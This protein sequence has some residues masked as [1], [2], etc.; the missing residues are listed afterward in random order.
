MNTSNIQ[1]DNYKIGFICSKS[2][3]LVY[4]NNRLQ[5]IKI[6]VT[7][8]FLGFFESSGVGAE[9]P[10]SVFCSSLSPFVT[11]AVS[12]S[13]SGSSCFPSF[14]VVASFSFSG[15]PLSSCFSLSWKEIPLY[16]F[17]E[18][19]SKVVFSEHYLM[20]LHILSFFVLGK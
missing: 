13:F 8:S 3:I 2:I 15:V 11:A 16:Y 12:L 19:L 14:S 6:K 18:F 10:F 17:L 5:F 20:Q 1:H 7:F 4:N 9:S